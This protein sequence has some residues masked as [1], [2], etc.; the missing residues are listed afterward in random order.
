MVLKLIKAFPDALM[1]QNQFGGT[2]ASIA[3]CDGNS[4]VETD[5]LILAL[6]NANPRV[7]KIPNKH[8]YYLLHYIGRNTKI[9]SSTIDF[10]IS[11]HPEAL[12]ERNIYGATPIFLAMYWDAPMETIRNL[13]EAAPSAVSIRDERGLCTISSAWNLFVRKTKVD[14]ENKTNRVLGNREM[15]QRAELPFDL[16]GEVGSWW[17]KMELLL[18]A[19]Y[20]NTI[21]KLPEQK[22]W[23]ILH[24][25][26]GGNSP[27]NLI[28]FATKL[29]R[30]Q[31]F[32]KDEDGRLPL[33]IA[34][35]NE[36]YVSQSFEPKHKGVPMLAL[37]AHINRNAVTD[38]DNDGRIPLHIALEAGK[39]WGDGISQ[40]IQHIPQILRERDP[41][42]NLYPFM[43][44]AIAFEQSSE[45]N[46]KCNKIAQG[47]FKQKDW[48]MMTVHERYHQIERIMEQSDSDK[49]NTVSV[50]KLIFY[51][52]AFEKFGIHV[53]L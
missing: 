25:T 18:K 32:L 34:A 52:E 35:R 10:L 2:P 51:E 37:L 48:R 13:L 45:L 12:Y 5:D 33:H 36:I 43:L 26:V 41:I 8:G 15:M 14:A 7:A 22:Q 40:M 4:S 28:R 29:Y 46:Q 38:K 47:Q 19:S 24:A 50:C 31:L 44:S 49:F 3:I 39:T 53:L 11:L 16:E 6:L 17:E 30:N 21:A 1:Y 27:P 42:T 20:H 23:K 9:K